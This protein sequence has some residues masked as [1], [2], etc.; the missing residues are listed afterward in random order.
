MTGERVLVTGGSGFIGGWCALAALDAGYDVRATVRDLG[1]ADALRA[2]LHDAAEFDDRRL[3]VVRADLASDD[4]WADAMREVGHVLH[5]A[6]P[7]L[8]NG[9]MAV[10]DMVD[11]AR[12]G[13]RRV[14]RAARDGGAKRVVLTSA[15]GAIVYGHPPRTEPFTEADWTNL[16]ADIPAYQRSKTLAERAAWDF[17]ASEGGGLELAV[18]NPTA[19][20]GPL[21]GTDDPPSLRTI[22]GMLDGGLPICPPFGTGWVDVRD[23]ADLHLRAM[24]DPRAS[25]ER[26]LATSGPSLRMVQV[27]RILRERLGERGVKAPARE[28]PLWVAR[29]LSLVNPQLRA[30][31]PQLGQ[32]FPSSAAKAE[33]LLG[34]RPRPVDDSIVDTAESLFAH[35]IVV[36]VGEA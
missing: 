34:W 11:A 36:P 2:H 30:I 29:A 21:L 8:R 31:R 14:L 22:R 13:V 27:A 25:G 1:K 24:T 12:G 26:F 19:V 5:V 28:M 7:T 9:P 33:R 16:D 3:T 23:V 15:S 20:L 6:S 17:I 18:I 32:E 35:G 4:G 10:D